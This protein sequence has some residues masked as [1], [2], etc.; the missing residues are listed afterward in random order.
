[1]KCITQGL[2]ALVYASFIMQAVASDRPTFG[3]GHL[4]G[5]DL[6]RRALLDY[7][8]VVSVVDQVPTVQPPTPKVSTW[9]PT[10]RKH[11]SCLPYCQTPTDP[12]MHP[13][14]PPLHRD[15][16]PPVTSAPFPPTIY[17]GEKGDPQVYDPTH[18]VPDAYVVPRAG[19]GGVVLGSL[20]AIASGSSG[21]L[22]A[23]GGLAVIVSLGV[24][25]A[26]RDRIGTH[27]ELSPLLLRVDTGGTYGSSVSVS[28]MPSSEPCTPRFALADEL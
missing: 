21:T 22:A 6:H 28:I 7:D 4:R 3:M 5:E 1:M 13:S 25:S 20:L 23:I 9:A 17:S 18:V 14:A 27:S 2:L 8:F 12:D 26:R 16:G 24:Y 11:L 15:Y 10:P 19:G